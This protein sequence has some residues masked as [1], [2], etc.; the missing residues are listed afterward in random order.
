MYLIF[1]IIH[2]RK[3]RKFN[4][5]YSDAIFIKEKREG[6]R[7][8]KQKMNTIRNHLE[9]LNSFVYSEIELKS[10]IIFFR[11]VYCKQNT[12]VSYTSKISI[13]FRQGCRNFRHI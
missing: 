12:I 1:T 4:I 8:I 3:N 9:A 10:L 7:I 5:F 11:N 2:S 13:L 6:G